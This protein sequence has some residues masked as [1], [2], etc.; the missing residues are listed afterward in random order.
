MENIICDLDLNGDKPAFVGLNTKICYNLNEIIIAFLR[1]VIDF[2]AHT[3][4]TINPMAY[5]LTD[6]HPKAFQEYDE[7]FEYMK[8]MC[9]NHLYYKEIADLFE[10]ASEYFFKA[11]EGRNSKFVMGEYRKYRETLRQAF[12]RLLD[13]FD[14]LERV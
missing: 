3:S 1:D 11:K 9:A 13:V 2:Y 4:Q 7:G 14:Y 12:D 6:R 5:K 10:K 8:Y